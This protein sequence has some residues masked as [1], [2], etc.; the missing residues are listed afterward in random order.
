MNS[1]QVHSSS[2]TYSVYIGEN[3]RFNMKSYLAKEYSSILVIADEK[4][5]AL[6]LDNLTTSLNHNTVYQ[7]IIS[8]GEKSK[9]IKTFYELHTKAIACNLDRESLI[10]ALGGGVTGDLAGFVAATYMRGISYMQVP[11]TILAHD[12]SVGGKVAI[13][14]ESGKNLIG[15]FFPPVSVIYDVQTLQTLPP[16]EVRSGYGELIKEALIADESYFYNLLKTDLNEL[17]NH[18]LVDHL[19]KGIKIKTAIVEEDEKESGLRKHLNLGHTLAHALEAELGY[20]SL[21]HG[22]AVA[23][24][25]L[26]ALYVSKNTFSGNLP[27][28]VLFSWLKRNNYPLEL[29]QLD[30]D[31]L[32]HR[33]KSD[34]K[35]V[36]GNIQMVLLKKTAEPCVMEIQDHILKR[37]LLLFLETLSS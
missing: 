33:M 30:A 11:T 4:V 13:N 29:P 9:D 10:I 15:S 20:G 32:I 5:A 18:I 2:H 25:L 16:H 1:I 35:T 24:G 22:E 19:Y 34:K 31:I 23:I 36:N 8:A 3:I 37:Q 6:Y 14:H 7:A 28:K 17:D 12:S 26:F 21:T 27:N